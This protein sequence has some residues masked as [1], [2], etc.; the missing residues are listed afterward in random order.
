MTAHLA[1]VAGR[2]ERREEVLGRSA[3]GTSV[4]E[5]QEGGDVLYEYRLGAVV[6]ASAMT[7]HALV[8]VLRAGTA[9]A[10]GASGAS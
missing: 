1:P 5:V 4:I 8:Q 7:L 6:L 10:D 3:E 2:P 9:A